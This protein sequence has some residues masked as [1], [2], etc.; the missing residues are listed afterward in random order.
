MSAQNK[1]DYTAGNSLLKYGKVAAVMSLDHTC[2]HYF[3][4]LVCGSKMADASAEIYLG[5]S[6]SYYAIN[7]CTLHPPSQTY[8]H[9]NS[10]KWFLQYSFLALQR[11]SLLS[12]LATDFNITSLICLKTKF[13]TRD[14]FV[15]VS[16]PEFWSLII[17]LCNPMGWGGRNCP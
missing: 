4:S 14:F 3:Q 1:I 9:S 5:N 13:L 16:W 15:G 10:Y 6:G 12:L 8:A 11:W 2:C 7:L 17:T